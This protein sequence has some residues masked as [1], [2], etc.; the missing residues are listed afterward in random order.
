[1]CIRDRCLHRWRKI[2]FSEEEVLE[3]F[4][5]QIRREV[6]RHVNEEALKKIRCTCRCSRW[7][8]L[9][10]CCACAVK[11]SGEATCGTFRHDDV[12]IFSVLRP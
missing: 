2:V 10:Q 11:R 12:V 6:V 8:L 3:E 5:P 9:A 4:T 7:R 1:M